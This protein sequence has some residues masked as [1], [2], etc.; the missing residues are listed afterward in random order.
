MFIKFFKG[1]QCIFKKGYEDFDFECEGL[2]GP[3]AVE[4]GRPSTSTQHSKSSIQAAMSKTTSQDSKGGE[5][6]SNSG[7]Q[8]VIVTDTDGPAQQ[9]TTKFSLPTTN[10]CTGNTNTTQ[11]MKVNI[12]ADCDKTMDT[13]K[14]RRKAIRPESLERTTAEVWDKSA[15]RYPVE[16]KNKRVISESTGDY[17]P[18]IFH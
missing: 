10:T 4:T 16:I 1:F 18:I 11:I 17:S 13:T 14:G 15:K 3:P 5:T 12:S 8:C 6:M 2:P 7:S 9:T